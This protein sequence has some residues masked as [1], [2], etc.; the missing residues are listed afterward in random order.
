M[1]KWLVKY[2]RMSFIGV[3]VT[4][5]LLAGINLWALHALFD[6]SVENQ[7]GITAAELRP[8]F[9]ALGAIGIVLAV[10]AALVRIPQSW[11]KAQPAKP[12][13]KSR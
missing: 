13:R 5:T 2:L 12:R 1:P 10:F 4:M 8:L 11:L 3:G 6:A 9:Y 7:L